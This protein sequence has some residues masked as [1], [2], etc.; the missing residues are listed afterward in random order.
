[1]AAQYYLQTHVIP[2][3]NTFNKAWYVMEWTDGAAAGVGPGDTFTPLA[4]GP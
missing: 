2:S 4:S 3:L 1:M